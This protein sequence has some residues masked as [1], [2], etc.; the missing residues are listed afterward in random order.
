M[1]IDYA[2]YL[3]NTNSINEKKMS[4][5]SFTTDANNKTAVNWVGKIEMTAQCDE[6]VPP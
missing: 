5:I 3:L 1:V 6:Y 4:T 2:A